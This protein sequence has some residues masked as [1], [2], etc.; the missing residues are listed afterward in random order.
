LIDSTHVAQSKTVECINNYNHNN[1]E[2]VA[3]LCFERDGLM[4]IVLL[5]RMYAMQYISRVVS[6]ASIKP[7][8]PSKPIKPINQ[9]NQSIN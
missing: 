4:K 7:S 6:D 5:D 3:I 9:A 1:D 8:K 2:F